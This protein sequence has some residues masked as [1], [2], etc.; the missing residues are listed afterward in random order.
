MRLIVPLCTRQY[1][2]ASDS[3]T[4][5]LTAPLCTW[6][7]NYAPDSTILHL[8]V[9]SCTWKYHFAPDNTVMHPTVPLCTWLYHYAPDSTIMHLTTPLW[10]TQFGTL[11]TFMISEKYSWFVRVTFACQHR[12]KRLV[13]ITASNYSY[14]KGLRCCAVRSACN[15]TNCEES[16]LKNSKMLLK[17]R[18]PLT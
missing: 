18:E 8:T 17:S 15:C 1:H 16:R 3:T 12:D 5:H 13:A 7:Y 4:V 2:Y 6:Q 14:L 11:N 10:T 9:P